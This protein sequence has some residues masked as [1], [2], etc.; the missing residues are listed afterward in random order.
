MHIYIH[1]YVSITRHIL[2]SIMVTHVCYL[3]VQTWKHAQS[4]S[5]LGLI[6]LSICIDMLR[7]AYIFDEILWMAPMLSASQNWKKWSL[8]VQHCFRFHSRKQRLEDG[9][10]TL[11][12]LVLINR[13]HGAKNGQFFGISGGSPPAHLS[14]QGIN[15]V[16]GPCAPWLMKWRLHLDLI[17]S[18]WVAGKVGLKVAGNVT[19]M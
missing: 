15:S 8:R 10:F 6:W 18:L 2:Y 7:Y 12:P 5:N 4:S 19:L 3:N 14:S 11:K 1:M 17:R 16:G 9:W 13:H